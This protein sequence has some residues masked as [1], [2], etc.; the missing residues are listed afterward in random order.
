MPFALN[1]RNF[2]VS[3]RATCEAKAGR[4]SAQAHAP[5]VVSVVVA[6]VRDCSGTNPSRS[7]V[8]IPTMAST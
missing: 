3:H 2:G 8:D 4:S 7:P 6:G 1:V 5:S